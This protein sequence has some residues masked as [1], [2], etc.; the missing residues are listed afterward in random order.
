[1]IYRKNFL[2][3]GCYWNMCVLL[4]CA[5]VFFLCTGAFYAS[6][7][8]FERELELHTERINILNR[9]NARFA[10]E[11][12]RQMLSRADLILRLMKLDMETIGYISAE[13]QA[14]LKS[15]RDSQSIDQITVADVD[16][17]LI[18]SAEPCDTVEYLP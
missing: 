3:T 2:F 1:M 12:I 18:F 11:N 13:R 5:L 14:I 15:L 4:L 17:N 7:I 6:K 10:E 8:L 16:G 9:N